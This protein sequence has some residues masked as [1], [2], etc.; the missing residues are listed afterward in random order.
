MSLSPKDLAVHYVEPADLG[1]EFKRLRV[2]EDGDFLDEWPAGFF[3]ER[4][5]ELF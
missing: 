1:T 3:D 5:G 4:D 2:S